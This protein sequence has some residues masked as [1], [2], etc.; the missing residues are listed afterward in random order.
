MSKTKLLCISLSNA[1]QMPFNRSWCNIERYRG[2][3]PAWKRSC[4]WM[5]F[6]FCR[7]ITKWYYST[8]A[9]GSTISMGLHRGGLELHT[10]NYRSTAV[11]VATVIWLAVDTVLC[12][13]IL[14][15]STDG[16]RTEDT[17]AYPRQKIVLQ[18]EPQ[19]L[20]WKSFDIAKWWEIFVFKKKMVSELLGY[21]LPSSFSYCLAVSVK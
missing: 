19:C 17:C 14:P 13:L 11:A 7:P 2:I 21:P 9:S 20:F 16:K 15:M 6:D 1:N 4:H 3:A 8:T 18:F 12:S 10:V 5:T